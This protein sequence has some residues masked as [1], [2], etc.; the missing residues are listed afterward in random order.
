MKLAVSAFLTLA[1]VPALAAQFDVLVFSREEF[2]RR[3]QVPGT[4]PYWAKKEGKLLRISA[5]IL[6]EREGQK[7]IVIGEEGANLKRVGTAARR[8]LEQITGDSRHA[9][10][11]H[12]IDA[13]LD[14]DT[15]RDI[16]TPTQL[17]TLAR[18]LLE[19]AFPLVL[20]EGEIGN[21]SRP[22]SGHLYFTLKDARAQVRCALFRSNAARL[23]FAP[24]DGS[25]PPSACF[26]SLTSCQALSASKRLMY[27]GEPPS[28]WIGSSLPSCMG[29]ALSRG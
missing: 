20:V 15:A 6:V 7:S 17:N 14:A 19:G 25:L 8:E 16:L 2:E 12:A 3:S 24:R 18:D 11:M 23:R 28:T 4:V 21:L 26:S 22:G 9:A 13:S 29:Q 27:P 5:C 1:S 10:V